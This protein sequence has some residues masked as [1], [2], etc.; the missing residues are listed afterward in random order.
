MNGTSIS[1]LFGSLGVHSVGVPRGTIQ[2]FATC[3]NCEALESAVTVAPYPPGNPLQRV[4]RKVQT[5]LYTWVQRQSKAD[6][7]KAK[8]SV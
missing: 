1:V 5:A 2:N 6:L 8:P 4:T 3:P 7:A